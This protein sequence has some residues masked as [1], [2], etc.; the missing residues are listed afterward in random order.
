MPPMGW[1]HEELI[2]FYGMLVVDQQSEM[3]GLYLPVSEMT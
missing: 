1:R 3:L 2:E